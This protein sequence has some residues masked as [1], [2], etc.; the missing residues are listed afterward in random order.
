MEESNHP[1][2]DLLDALI[3]DEYVEVP[4]ELEASHH[5]DVLRVDYGRDLDGRR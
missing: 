2:E 1:E 3:V 4:R 5:P